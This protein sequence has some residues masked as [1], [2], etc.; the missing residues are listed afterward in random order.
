MCGEHL[1]LE[2]TLLTHNFSLV[3]ITVSSLLSKFLNPPY[4]Y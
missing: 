4:V 2:R 1:S 3:M